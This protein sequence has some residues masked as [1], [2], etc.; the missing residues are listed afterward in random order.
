MVR[1]TKEDALET[2]NQLLD[3][4]ERV[5]LDKGFSHTSL[6]DVANA[7]GLTRGAVYWHF[8]NKADLFEA[9]VERVRLP[10]ETLGDCGSTGEYG[11]PLGRLREFA[12]LALK[13]TVVNQRRRRVFTILFHKFE[14]NEEAK[15]IES[16]QQ[17]AFLDC[18]QR[19]EQS[20]QNAVEK[21]QL[22][23][24]LNVH[25]SAIAFQAFFTGLLSNWL[26]MPRNFDLEAYAEP[27][28]D[29]FFAMLQ[30]SRAL[31]ETVSISE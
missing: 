23:P 18:L 25:S 26:F 19:I 6:N 7:A 4:A 11:D 13:E 22:P 15:S 8:K 30:N 5:F 28:V 16:R 24:D 1:K 29:S 14:Y 17:A 12:M 21:G 9:M 10:A 2:R 31:R 20:L 27:M 3:A